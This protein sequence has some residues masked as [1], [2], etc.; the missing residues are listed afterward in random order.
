MT[1]QVIEEVIEC[2]IRNINI[3][4]PDPVEINNDIPL[5]LKDDKLV[6]LQKSDPH[7]NKLRKQWENNN[8]DRNTYT[9]EN[10]ILKWKIIEN[11]L[12]YTSIVV[13][14]ILKDC[15]LI[16]AHDKQGHNGSRRTYS[17]LKN[18]YY[19]KGIKKSVHQHCTN[20][21]VCAKHNIKTQQLKNK[22]FSSPP[23]PMEF[24]AMDLIG[25]FHPASIKGNRYALTAVCML[26]GFTFCIPLKI[27]MCRGPDK[28][29]HRPHM[30]PL[31]TIKENTHR[32][33]H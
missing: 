7:T 21:K 33:W 3:Q 14:D 26:T 19:W 31:R 8:L 1:T 10:N 29:L 6:Q 11:G 20:C 17:S 27:Q 22:H 18:R 15:L 28:G 16:L 12:L 5:P 25:E 24:I 2:E 30:L 32:Q 4:H 9:M 13:P 23:Q